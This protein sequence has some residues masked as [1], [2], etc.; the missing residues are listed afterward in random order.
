[1]V[2]NG[3]WIMFNDKNNLVGGDWNMAFYF[4]ISYMER[5]PSH[6]LFFKMVETTKQNTFEYVF[7]DEDEHSCSSA[8]FWCST[9]VWNNLTLTCP[10]SIH[11]VGWNDM[12]V[13]SPIAGIRVWSSKSQ[14]SLIFEGKLGTCIQ[15]IHVVFYGEKNIVSKTQFSPSS[16]IPLPPGIQRLFDWNSII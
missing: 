10:V 7:L 8:M 4:S 6:W 11:P 12:D 2:G 5:H 1:M 9:A 14:I 15:E 16:I 13:W 3:W